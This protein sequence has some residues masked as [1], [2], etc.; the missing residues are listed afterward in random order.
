MRTSLERDLGQTVSIRLA[1]ELLGVSHTALRRWVRSGDLA[2]VF[3]RSGAQEIPL[4]TVLDLHDTISAARDAGRLHVIEPAIREARER[5]A[6]LKPA[7]LVSDA[8]S[9]GGHSAA[10]RRALAYHRAVAKRL[11]REDVNDAR[12]LLRAWVKDGRI[13]RRYAD[14]WDRLL[15]LPMPAIRKTLAEDTQQMRDLRQNSPFAG[16]LSEPERARIMS[17]V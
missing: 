10:E 2:T 17:E 15:A 7:S 6:K 4:S 9:T 16:Q 12:Q 3:A 13:D 14:M 5:A 8:S 11:R 1:S